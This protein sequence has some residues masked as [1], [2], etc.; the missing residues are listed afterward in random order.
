MS[1]RPLRVLFLTRY[2]LEGASSLQLY[3]LKAI[4]T[5]MLVGVPT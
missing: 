2:P 4:I 5:A 3:Q 1:D